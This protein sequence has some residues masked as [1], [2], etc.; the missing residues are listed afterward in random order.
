[1]TTIY[2]GSRGP[3]EIATMNGKHAATAAAKLRREAP[4]RVA[5][6]EA[7]EARRPHG[8]RTRARI[9]RRQRWPAA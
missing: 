9:D 3:V 5:E 6:I 1:M 8:R 7:L 2:K 4:E